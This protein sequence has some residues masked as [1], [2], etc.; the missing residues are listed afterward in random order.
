MK[1][2]NANV[3]GEA[4][5]QNAPVSEAVIGVE[6]PRLPF[7]AWH[8]VALHTM[9][10]AEFPHHETK[11]PLPPAGIQ[12]GFGFTVGPA[13]IEGRYWFIDPH[14]GWL[15]QLQ[16]DRLILNWRKVPEAAYPG[17]GV[18]REKYIRYWGDFASYVSSLGLPGPYPS[19]VE[20][21]YVNELP[22]QRSLSYFVNLLKEAPEGLPGTPSHQALQIKRAIHPTDSSDATGELVINAAESGIDQA[23]TLTIVTRLL[24]SGLDQVAPRIEDAHMLSRGT[25]DAITSDEAQTGWGR[26]R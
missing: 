21:T 26:G 18:V 12:P 9:W 10:S 22:P 23:T 5:Y 17:F 4:T 8:V 11:P 3:G 14:D 24:C 19:I 13:P 1:V 15:I 7:D 16:N 6:F 2:Q 25:F 20:Y